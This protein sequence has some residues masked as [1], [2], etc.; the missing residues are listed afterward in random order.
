M[1]ECPVGYEL[2]R[3]DNNG[4]YEPSNCRWA[5]HME[6]CRNRR[7]N[8]FVTMFNKTLCF[9]DMCEY[10]GVNYKMAHSRFRTLGWSIEDA[11]LTPKLQQGAT[12]LGHNK[13]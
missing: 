6:Q 11:I 13:P 7:P 2:D 9:K 12:H 8:V 1:G 3:I 4:N 5:D 10:V